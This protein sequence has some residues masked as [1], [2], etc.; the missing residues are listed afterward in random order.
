MPMFQ[1]EPSSIG[2]V[3]APAATPP[4]DGQQP[5]VLQRRSGSLV[6]RVG[7]LAVRA[8]VG[9]ARLLG[10][11]TWCCPRRWHAIRPPESTP[12]SRTTVACD[13]IC[14][15]WTWPLN[16]PRDP[17]GAGWP[18]R[19]TGTPVGPASPAK[20]ASGGARSLGGPQFPGSAG[21][22]AH[23]SVREAG[24]RLGELWKNLVDLAGGDD[25]QRSGPVDR[26]PWLRWVRC[27]ELPQR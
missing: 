7:H 17:A 21:A 10:E 2:Q 4:A 6:G 15:V 24:L 26:L 18:T 11:V 8:T 5:A 16:I 20:A 27:E 12:T 23:L 3:R 1:V 19:R 22:A 13:G 9:L 14:R 25:G